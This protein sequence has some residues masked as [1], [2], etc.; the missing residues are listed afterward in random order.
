MKTLAAEAAF[1]ASAP[2][3][4]DS[5]EISDRDGRRLLQ[6]VLGGCD[7][8]VTWRRAR[9]VSLS[10]QKMAV[11]QIGEVVSVE[12]GTVRDV[13]HNFCRDG[14]DSLDPRYRGGPSRTL[15][16][17]QRDEIRRIALSDPHG[18]GQP[19]AA[20]SPSR[21]AD[22]LVGEAIIGDISHDDLRVLLRREGV[23]LSPG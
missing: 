11:D 21:L 8:V 4:A 12:C 9:I 18:L 5:P 22:Y 19:F 6:I 20:W 10:A 23:D 13:I 15:A 7:S 14:F 3:A 1:Q 17:T 16:R 2:L